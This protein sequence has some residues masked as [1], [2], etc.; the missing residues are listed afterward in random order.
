MRCQCRLDA[1]NGEFE[2]F[3]LAQ[4]DALAQTVRRFTSRLAAALAIYIVGSVRGKSGPMWGLIGIM[5]TAE[6]LLP[7][8]ASLLVVVGTFLSLRVVLPL[9]D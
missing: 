2:E 5:E 9:A 7:D 4:C 8:E 3:T 1:I 6:F